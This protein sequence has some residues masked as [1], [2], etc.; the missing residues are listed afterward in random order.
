MKHLR[1][2]LPIGAMAVWVALLQSGCA[3]PAMKTAN[4][5]SPE[6]A[7]IEEEF[8]AL[9]QAFEESNPA[10]QKEIDGLRTE[11]QAMM[12]EKDGKLRDLDD[13]TKN[14]GN[15]MALLS[16][17]VEQLSKR[18]ENLNPKNPPKAV[19][20][21][22]KEELRPPGAQTGSDSKPVSAPDARK[23]D[24]S[25]QSA[26]QQYY[27]EQYDQAIGDFRKI[28]ADG[29]ESDLADNAQYWIAE[30]YYSKRQYRHALSAF[31]QVF[32]YA[33]TNKGDAAQFKIALCYRELGER[34]K[35]RDEL[36]KLVQDYPRSEFLS[37]AQ[38]ELEASEE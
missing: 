31:K 32:S 14:L 38:S 4:V 29:P 6:K 28:L 22:K 37:R 3:G 8:A 36:N 16:D 9:K 21:A 30:C 20:P 18:F 13:Q 15:R 33:N 11:L 2:G 25:Y 10:T 1:R 26:L 24:S 34:T 23:I 27:D 19:S 5:P 12:A 17:Q 7:P 35:A